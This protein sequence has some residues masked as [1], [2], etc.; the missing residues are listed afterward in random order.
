MGARIEQETTVQYHAR[1]N[2]LA[3]DLIA[4][5]DRPPWPSHYVEDD[6]DGPYVSLVPDDPIDPEDVIAVFNTAY[7]AGR[8]KGQMDAVPF[9]LLLLVIGLIGGVLW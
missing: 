3:H 4:A 5:T 9:A 8:G 6:T 2:K 7:K 1:V